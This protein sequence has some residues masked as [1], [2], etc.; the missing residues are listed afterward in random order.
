MNYNGDSVICFQFNFNLF[1]FLQLQHIHT[2]IYT[3]KKYTI[4]D[5][6][7]MITVKKSHNK[8]KGRVQK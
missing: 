8:S 6:N 4:Y 7:T 1:L 5:K 2:T 3:L